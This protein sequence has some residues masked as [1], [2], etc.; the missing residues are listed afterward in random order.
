MK[1][2]DCHGDY[3]PEGACISCP[4]EDA[5]IQDTIVKD[6]HYD[7][8]ASI[9]DELAFLEEEIMEREYDYYS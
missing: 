1:Y 7:T 8:L 6:N 3:S 4:Y 2:P 9:A 5:C